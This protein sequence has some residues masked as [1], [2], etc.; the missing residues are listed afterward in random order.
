M[1]S[2]PY[3]KIVVMHE[4]TSRAE[5]GIHKNMCH[6]V[7]IFILKSIHMLFWALPKWHQL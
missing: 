2:A 6:K 7:H 4:I 1:L 5:N 3:R